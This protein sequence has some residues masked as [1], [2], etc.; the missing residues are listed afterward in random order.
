MI[1]QTAY[2]L[3]KTKILPDTS[4]IISASIQA[5]VKNIGI[6][7]KHRQYD[8][9]IHLFSIFRKNVNESIG[10][11]TK[12]IR[13]ESFHTLSKAVTSS[14]LKNPPAEKDKR[15]KLFNETNAIINICDNKMRILFS[16]LL[17]EIPSSEIIP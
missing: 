6:E 15:K 8:E 2:A 5:N 10:I 12:T 13:G 14:I 1:C 11:T 3:T 7:V 4:V 16:N 17:L 9:S